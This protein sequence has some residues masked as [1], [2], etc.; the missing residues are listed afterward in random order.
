M[1]GRAGNKK[2]P[3][4]GHAIVCPL[5]MQQRNDGIPAVTDGLNVVSAIEIIEKLVMSDVVCG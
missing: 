3:A 5:Y 1:R 2:A 4:G